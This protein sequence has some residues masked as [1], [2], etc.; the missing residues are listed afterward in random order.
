MGLKIHAPGGWYPRE[1]PSQV[2]RDLPKGTKCYQKVTDARDTLRVLVVEVPYEGWH[3]S[4]TCD[5][6]QP[7]IKECQAARYHLVPA[8]VEM[9]IPLFSTTEQD[10]GG[11]TINLV[12]LPIKVFED[13]LGNK[14][15]FSWKRKK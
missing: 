13:H 8:T 1:L 10:Q 12:Q 5:N 11:Y 7:T 9:G 4:V 6:R 2:L 14:R 3:C 15:R